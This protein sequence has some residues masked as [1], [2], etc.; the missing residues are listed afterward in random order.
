LVQH[1]VVVLPGAFF[2]PRGREYVR[3]AVVPDLA[4]CQEAVQILDRVLTDI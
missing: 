2:G 3:L 1:G 4:V